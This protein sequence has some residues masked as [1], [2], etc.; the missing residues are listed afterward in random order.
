MTAKG[1]PG[2]LELNPLAGIRIPSTMA[3]P[4]AWAAGHRAALPVARRVAGLSAVAAAAMIVAGILSDDPDGDPWTIT[5]FLVGYA[6]IL[7]GAVLG[8]PPPAPAERG[9]EVAGYR[10]S[11][12]AARVFWRRDLVGSLRDPERFE[13]GLVGMV[14]AGAL[15]PP[16]A[17]CRAPAGGWSWPRPS[18]WPTLLPVCGPTAT[19]T[20]WRPPVPPR[21]T[22]G[23]PHTSF[24]S[25][26]S[27]R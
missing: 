2:S 1:A 26:P 19:G 8:P 10:P 27:S 3:W 20:S 15:G 13:L 22:G 18:W 12:L 4:R 9:R 24:S 14:A 16:R 25:T 17:R 7:G 5:L 23:A 6:V 11:Q 21:S